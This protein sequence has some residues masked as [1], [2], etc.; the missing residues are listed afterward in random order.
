MGFLFVSLF[1]YFR[2]NTHH[3]PRYTSLDK[4][5]NKVANRSIA[6]NTHSIKILQNGS[7]T[8]QQKL[9][10]LNQSSAKSSNSIAGKTAQ[11]EIDRTPLLSPEER[12]V[13]QEDERIA[14]ESRDEPSEYVPPTLPGMEPRIS[15][16]ELQERTSSGNGHS[17][18]RKKKS[19][20][21]RASDLAQTTEEQTD[22]VI[23]KGLNLQDR[24]TTASKYRVGASLPVELAMGD[25]GERLI[26][27]SQAVEE[28]R[29]KDIKSGGK[30]AIA[31]KVLNTVLPGSGGI[32]NAFH[33]VAQGLETNDIGDSSG[34]A[35]LAEASH[36]VSSSKM[37][38]G[39]SQ[40]ASTAGGMAAGALVGQIA[41]PIPVLGAMLGAA[42]GLLAS[43]GIQKGSDSLLQDKDELR[44]AAD[45]IFSHAYQGDSKALEI[46]NIFEIDEAVA[47]EEDGWKI[48][49]K[50][51]G[52]S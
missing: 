7:K 52:I 37:K 49:Y 24:L 21:E 33:T 45:T 12:A 3:I 34:N 20:E 36:T 19:L 29:V 4:A 30:S 8:I 38:K 15:D 48:I 41:I 2:V 46:L 43:I 26:A 13:A 18:E 27:D 40:V 51:L 10:E 16:V 23:R 47:Q 32:A 22:D 9:K 11:L 44:A 31:K 1:G 50:R 35:E 5:K 25:I 42:A 39:G 6:N 28:Q 17:P 14:A